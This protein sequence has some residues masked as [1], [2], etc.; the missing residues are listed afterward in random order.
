MTTIETSS[1]MTV[2]L[3]DSMASDM[4]VTR[5]AQVSVKGENSPNTDLPRLINYLVECRHGSP[6]EHSV[7]TW[8]VEAPIFV[9]REFHR[10]RIASY[11][12]MSGRYTKLLPKF[13]TPGVERPLVNV[14]SSARP[15][16]EGGSTYQRTLVSVGDLKVFELAW[17]EYESRIDEMIERKGEWLW[18]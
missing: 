4:H 1:E 9:F 18:R 6:F 13:Y 5:A 7:F 10:H 8:F 12:E 14:A 17:D 2:K 16:F 3:I 11:N 15:E